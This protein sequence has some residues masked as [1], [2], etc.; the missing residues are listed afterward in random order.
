MLFQPH[1]RENALLDLPEM[2]AFL[3]G[4]HTTFKAIFEAI[5]ML[6]LFS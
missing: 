5:I 4:K 3:G 2:M 6:L 1:S